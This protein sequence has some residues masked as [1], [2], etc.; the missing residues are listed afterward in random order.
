MAP[1]AR[2]P[3]LRMALLIHFPWRPPKPVCEVPS[4]SGPPRLAPLYPWPNAA[5]VCP[6]LPTVPVVPARIDRGGAGQPCVSIIAAFSPRRNLVSLALLSCPL[7]RQRSGGD[8]VRRPSR[9]CLESPP[10]AL[11]GLSRGRRNVCPISANRGNLRQ[12]H[13]SRP[14]GAHVKFLQRQS[15]PADSRPP[16]TSMAVAYRWGA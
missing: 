12:D 8:R 7:P 5:A 3:S 14:G 15:G 1:P 2:P 13:S 16:L 9:H 10:A 11:A 6:F 4:R